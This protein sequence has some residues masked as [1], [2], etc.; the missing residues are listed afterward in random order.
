MTQTD[1]RI[2]EA[3]PED[4]QTILSL[5]NKAF[6]VERYFL[7]ADRMDNE[8]LSL[9]MNKGRFLVA[10]DDR[11]RMVGCVY[12]ELSGGSAYLGLLSIDPER[13][14]SG[15]GAVLVDAVEEQARNAGCLSVDLRVVDI[16][17]DLPGYYRRL[18]YIETGTAPFPP[19][20]STNQPCG[21]ILMS[22][23]L[24]RPD[25]GVQNSMGSGVANA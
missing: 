21:F 5:I 12:I 16:R 13:Q 24:D 15:I 23:S 10:E 1:L 8:R 20:I 17:R 7:D 3:S 25:H 11:G 9:A 22:K 14:R 19:D 4:A 18:G 6:E 2:R